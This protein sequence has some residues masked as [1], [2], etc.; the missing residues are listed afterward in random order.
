M[1]A[2]PSPKQ[3]A[4][5]KA[6]LK[7]HKLANRAKREPRVKHERMK[8]RGGRGAEPEFLRWLHDHAGLCIACEIEGPIPPDRLK[9][10]GIP[11]RLEAAHQRVRGWKKGVRGRD[12]DS[13]ILCAFHHQHAPDACDRGWRQ[14]WERLNVDPAAYCAELYDAF[15]RGLDGRAVVMKHARRGT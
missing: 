1:N 9:M 2:P 12:A 7:R 6:V 13:C 8:D 5:A 3:V 4:E 11:N 14:F 15:K 10:W